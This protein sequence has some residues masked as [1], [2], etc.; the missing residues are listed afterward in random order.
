MPTE[1]WLVNLATKEYTKVVDNGEFFDV[2]DWKTQTPFAAANYIDL[3]MQK[4]WPDQKVNE[5]MVWGNDLC[6]AG[7]IVGLY[8]D[9]AYVTRAE[10]DAFL[11][12]LRDKQ[13][14]AQAYVHE[15]SF[16]PFK[17]PAMVEDAEVE[18]LI[19]DI[20]LKGFEFNWTHVHEESWDDARRR[21]MAGGYSA[22]GIEDGLSSG[23]V[24]PASPERYYIRGEV[25]SVG[26]GWG[27][28]PSTSVD[29]IEEAEAYQG[30]VKAA[31]TKAAEHAEQA[32]GH[33]CMGDFA[34]AMESLKA[35]AAEESEFSDAD[36]F[37]PLVERL[38]AI[39]A[40]RKP[41]PGPKM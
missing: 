4:V 30:R 35:A 5:H 9:K 15:L 2:D 37:D 40:K 14:V 3:S 26:P 21:M 41:S 32:V 28:I 18:A 20:P 29:A 27:P 19:A 11:A 23:G 34:S 36:T 13:D 38:E 16:V 7:M 12:D 31:I 1:Y 39:I 33:L 17:A 6:S 10:A 25:V 8:F 22:E 24:P